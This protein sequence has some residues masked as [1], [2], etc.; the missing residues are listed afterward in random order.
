MNECAGHDSMSLCLLVIVIESFAVRSTTS[1]STPLCGLTPALGSLI[2]FS[3]HEFGA[4]GCPANVPPTCSQVLKAEAVNGKHVSI[5]RTVYI[6][7]NHGN[8]L[9]NV[10]S[11]HLDVA[12]FQ[13]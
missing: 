5:H 7:R 13:L 2:V 3:H 10:A 4:R 9:M 6:P 8:H 11:S 1:S 12:K